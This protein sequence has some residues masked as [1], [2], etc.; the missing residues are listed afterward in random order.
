MEF[1]RLE[2][3]STLDIANVKEQD[4]DVTLAKLSNVV[5][6]TQNE[7]FREQLMP[8]LPSLLVQIHCA[9]DLMRYLRLYRGYLLV[10]RN[11]MVLK[12]EVDINSVLGGLQSFKNSVPRSH[13]MFLKTLLVFYQIL[14]NIT[15]YTTPQCIPQV[16]DVMSEVELECDELKLP[17][18]LLLSNL[19]RE[20][21][22][23]YQLLHQ[24]NAIMEYLI[25][26]F[27][28]QNL[29]QL[30]EYEV[31]V[32]QMFQTIISHESYGSWIKNGQTPQVL[33]I[34]QLIIGSKDNWDNYQLVGILSWLFPMVE[35]A[36]H[37]TI[38]WFEEKDAEK[39]QEIHP[40]LLSLLDCLSE[41]CQFNVAKDF[42][43]TYKLV[44]T[45]VPLLRTVHD[46]IG[47]KNMMKSAPTESKVNIDFPHIKSILIEILSYLTYDNFAVQETIR[48][49]HGLEII[50]SNCVI[51]DNNPYIKERAI[52]CLKYLL[53][54]NPGN[55]QFVASL[56][57]RKEVDSGVL[58][59]LNGEVSFNNGN[60]EL[61]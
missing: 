47:V 33:K 61:K 51:D 5:G 12:P 2:F 8:C 44:E 42:L 7:T 60:L 36:S 46:N 53:H 15:Q 28:L 9:N 29:D 39:L 18:T 34:N 3:I 58:Q 25:Q 56:E 13:D 22:N 41:L 59:E 35:S 4:F 55:Q 11:L 32:C 43:I 10:L 19:L 38:A 30:S 31:M 6:Q 54:K 45:L 23:T 57:A 27:S 49:L 48:E 52:I 14:A 1:N 37:L 24:G 17:V 21:E 50:L 26:E 20:P 16:C 40:Q